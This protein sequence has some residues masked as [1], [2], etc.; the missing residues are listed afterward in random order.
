MGGQFS[1]IEYAK[2]IKSFSE[3]QLAEQ[4]EKEL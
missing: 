4:H 3:V 1:A 2:Q